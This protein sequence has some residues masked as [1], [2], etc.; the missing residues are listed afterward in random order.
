MPKR[1]VL[2]KHKVD[3]WRKQDLAYW[4]ELKAKQGGM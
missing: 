4:L 3:L 1:A 2:N